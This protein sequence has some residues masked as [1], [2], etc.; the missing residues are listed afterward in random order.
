MTQ[1]A[2]L[3]TGARPKAWKEAGLDQSDLLA[4]TASVLGQYPPG[5]VVIEGEAA[6]ADVA[7]REAALLLDQ[8]VEAFPVTD[9]EWRPVGP[10]GR[11]FDRA[12]GLKRNE[13]MV[14]RL[15]ALQEEGFECHVHAFHPAGVAVLGLK[16]GSGTA[17][18]ARL[19]RANGFDVQVHAG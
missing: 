7:C 9:A 18:C 4:L 2:V 3:V 11:Y 6:G 13:R 14:D 8:E 15:M 16:R 17:H 1:I 12:A 10:N 5:T 19:A